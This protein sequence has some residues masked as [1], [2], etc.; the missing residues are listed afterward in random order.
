MKKSY[1]Y[2][3]ETIQNCFLAIYVNIK[4]PSDKLI[5]EISDFRNNLT[6]FVEFNKKLILHK[7]YIVSFNGLEF[8][9]QVAQYIMKNY[10]KRINLKGMSGGEVAREIFK[11]VQQLIELK[12]SKGWTIFRIHELP[13]NSIDLAA[14]NNYN[15]TQ[16]FASLKWLQYN[17]DWYNIMDMDC[18][19]DDIL[20][21]KDIIQLT[22]Y[23]INDNLSTRELLKKNIEQIEVRE[24]LSKHFGLELQN[25]SEPKL[26]KA[27]LSDL[28]SKDLNIEK[29]KL[30][31]MRTF[32]KKIHLKEAILPYISFKT[33]KLKET[34]AKFKS[35]VLDAENLKGSFHHKVVYRGLEFS[36]ALGGIHGAK[37]G[38]YK[39]GKG[40]VIKSFDVKSYYP[41]LCIRNQWSPEHFNAE[42]FCK[43][44]E[45]F[46]DE[47][48]KYP[49]SNPL[50][51][52]YKIVLNS[53]F[54]LSN[55]KN[56]FL[57]DSMLT[58]QITCN[59]QLLL[60]MLMERLCEEIPGA[61]PVMINTDGGEMILPK[62]YIPVYE[63]ICKEWE[64]QTNLILEFED[65]EKLIIWDVNN[66]IGVFKPKEIDKE[67]AI[68][69]FN[70]SYP[71]PLIKKDK[72]TGKVYHYP[73]KMKGRFEVDKALHKNKSFRVKPIAIYNYFVHGV[74]PEKSV[75]SN[76]NIYDFCAGVRAKG[77]WKILQTC[78]E[79]S[80]L[81][82]H[83][84]Q[85]TVRYYVSHKGCKLVK[86]KL[87][88][89]PEDKTITDKTG[90]VIKRVKEGDPII[91]EIK[92]E[93]GPTMEQVAIK[94][95]K[96]KP[97]EEYGVNYDF[98]LKAIRSEIETVEPSAT[99]TSLFD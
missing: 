60:V 92:V 58:M 25:L 51:Y 20:N 73:V 77:D 21:E 90:R 52:L 31:K 14:I 99:Q 30:L 55:D 36:F 44:Y 2:D 11:F 28:L 78:I 3:F 42:V 83:N 61:V 24:N 75:K 16:K 85:K 4:D 50:N 82:N 46:Y 94:I 68:T 37:R 54:G 9:D 79:D 33:Q 15:N 7:N 64:E 62:E 72:K 34:L 38:L 88:K 84:T 89:E 49:K 93:A 53:A 47:R 17:M 12:N 57:K 32:R 29:D 67:E 13:W 18:K 70:S 66:Y 1:V 63:K 97:F 98:Y 5:F 95:D 74:D 71:K 43:R 69:M 27:I 76:K 56:S 10:D 45:W 19:P 39:A 23:C 81:Y 40:M 91:R 80:E 96:N 22:K 48:L 59:G 65:Y 26:V 8:D 86:R 87:D 35:L 6:E 41:N